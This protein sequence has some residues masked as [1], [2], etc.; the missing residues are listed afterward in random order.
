MPKENPC[1]LERWIENSEALG[2]DYE[3]QISDEELPAFLS[4]FVTE[5]EPKLVELLFKHTAPYRSGVELFNALRGAHITLSF[6]LGLIE[7]WMRFLLADSAS[8]IRPEIIDSEREQQIERGQLHA[9]NHV[10]DD[11]ESSGKPN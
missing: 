10:E 11:N 7:E 1:L 4:S 6:Q 5:I 2:D 8:T 9:I 3:R